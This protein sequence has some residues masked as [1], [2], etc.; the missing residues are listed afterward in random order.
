MNRLVLAVTVFVVFIAPTFANH[1]ER[2]DGSRGGENG[3]VVRERL[4]IT[5]RLFDANRCMER[6]E[7]FPSGDGVEF[8]WSCGDKKFISMECVYDDTGYRDISPNLAPRG[9]HCNWPLPK[10]KLD[11]NNR[12][13]DVAVRSVG[14]R[15]AWA[16]CFVESYGDFDSREKPYHDTACYRSLLSIRNTVNQTQRDPNHVAKG[17]LQ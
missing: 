1:A 5:H 14:G 12:I 8:H 3:K 11:G 15:V 10:I 2:T 6:I 16:A 9:W 4:P 17:L 7:I 13:G